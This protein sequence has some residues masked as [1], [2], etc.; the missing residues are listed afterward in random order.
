MQ[1]RMGPCCP[2]GMPPEGEQE[3]YS[4]KTIMIGDYIK[5]RRVELGMTQGQLA[6]GICTVATLSRLEAGIQ[7]PPPQ[8]HQCSAAAAGT[9]GFPVFCHQYTGGSGHRGV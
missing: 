4:M 6:K 7:T 3:S 9:A 8:P 1:T 2:A 5:R